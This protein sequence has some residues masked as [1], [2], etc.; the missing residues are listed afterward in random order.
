MSAELLKQ[1]NL[2]TPNNTIKTSPHQPS[3][4]YTMGRN[5]WGAIRW[6]IPV[7]MLCSLTLSAM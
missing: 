5:G 1:G 7:S 3:D 2:Y 6:T 4:T